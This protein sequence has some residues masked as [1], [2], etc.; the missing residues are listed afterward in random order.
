MGEPVKVAEGDYI[1]D[2]MSQR[3]AQAQGDGAKGETTGIIP[4]HL[5]THPLIWQGDE[6]G[7][8]I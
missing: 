4:K 1:S 5:A 8:H 2:T 3:Q 6:I 7:K